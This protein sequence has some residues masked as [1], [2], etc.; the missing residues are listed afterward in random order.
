MT[1]Y[2]QMKKAGVKIEHHESDMYVPKNEV[3]DA[4]IADY[5]FK[6]NCEEFYSDMSQ[7]YWYDIPFAYDPY[8]EAKLGG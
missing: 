7:E 3:T 6:D 4:I 1:I 8:I 2:E 5:E